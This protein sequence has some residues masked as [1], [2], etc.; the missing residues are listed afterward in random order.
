M[1]LVSIDTSKLL[2]VLVHNYKRYYHMLNKLSNLFKLSHNLS[3]HYLILVFIE[4]NIS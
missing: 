2:P 1:P 4:T 3:V